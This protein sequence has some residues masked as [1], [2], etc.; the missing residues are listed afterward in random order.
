MDAIGD[1]IV[2]TSNYWGMQVSVV[3]NYLLRWLIKQFKSEFLSFNT[4]FTLKK[5]ILLKC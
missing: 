2:P 4:I 1:Q 5:N 3:L